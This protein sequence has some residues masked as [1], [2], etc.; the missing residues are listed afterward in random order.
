MNI[1]SDKVIVAVRGREYDPEDEFDPLERLDQEGDED[2]EDL[3][4]IEDKPEPV[5]KYKS[6]QDLANEVEPDELTE[7]AVDVK[8]PE[9]PK[10]KYREQ[11]N[12]GEDPDLDWRE[13]SDLADT[14]YKKDSNKPK[15]VLDEAVEESLKKQAQNPKEAKVPCP[16]CRGSGKVD[17]G[18]EPKLFTF[19]Y[20]A[21]EDGKYGIQLKDVAGKSVLKGPV[22]QVKYEDIMHDLKGIQALYGVEVPVRAAPKQQPGMVT[23]QEKLRDRPPLPY[24]KGQ[25][26]L[27]VRGE[28]KPDDLNPDAIDKAITR[29]WTVNEPQTKPQVPESLKGGIGTEKGLSAPLIPSEKPVQKLSEHEEEKPSFKMPGGWAV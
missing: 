19:D 29:S 12:L 27:G 20:Y 7:D 21:D 17:E 14:T 22:K 10:E 1:T 8:L 26:S 16:N 3:H 4:E 13:Q 6:I 11:H 5:Y 18:K 23:R 2:D 9:E 24:T 28:I 25:R 15:T